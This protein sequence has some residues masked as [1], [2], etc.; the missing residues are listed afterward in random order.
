MAPRVKSQNKNYGTNKSRKYYSRQF[1]ARDVKLLNLKFNIF[2]EC[3]L[4]SLLDKITLFIPRNDEMTF[5][6]CM[7]YEF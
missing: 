1:T 6:Y 3:L 2:N 4:I 7:V 5:C